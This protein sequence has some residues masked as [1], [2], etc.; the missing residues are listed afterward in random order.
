MFTVNIW[1]S[2]FKF[3]KKLLLGKVVKFTVLERNSYYCTVS[4]VKSKVDG[5]GG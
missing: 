5:P 1:K 2:A 4:G 3:I